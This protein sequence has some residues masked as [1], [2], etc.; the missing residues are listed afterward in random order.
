MRFEAIIELACR[1]YSVN[2]RFQFGS[3]TDG[4]HLADSKYKGGRSGTSVR[5]RSASEFSENS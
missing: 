2:V 3:N 4:S 5:Q 1:L